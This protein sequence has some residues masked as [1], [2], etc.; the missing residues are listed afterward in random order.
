MYLNYDNINLPKKHSF[1]SFTFFD[2]FSICIAGGFNGSSP[3]AKMS[4]VRLVQVAHPTILLP[5]YNDVMMAEYL[6]PV[7]T[8][9]IPIKPCQTNLYNLLY[10]KCYTSIPQVVIVHHPPP[11]PYCKTL[12]LL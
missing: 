11:P 9:I 8:L 1:V 12:L 6:V 5:G 10:Y 2:C 4:Y 3:G 7:I